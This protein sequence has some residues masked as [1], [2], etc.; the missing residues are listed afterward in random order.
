VITSKHVFCCGGKRTEEVKQKFAAIFFEPHEPH[1]NMVRWL[2]DGFRET[3]QVADAPRSGRSLV[4]SE[5]KVVNISVRITQSP[6]RFSLQLLSGQ[7]LI[8]I[9]IE[10]AL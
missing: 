8:I 7:H 1:R 4:L 5:D 2:S 10:R 6:K 3:G 9:N